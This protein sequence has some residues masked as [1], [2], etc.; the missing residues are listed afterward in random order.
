MFL[1]ARAILA[2]LF[3]L[4]LA[5]AVLAQEGSRATL[6]DR[7]K[8]VRVKTLL[9]AGKHTEAMPLLK[10]VLARHPRNTT[11][12]YLLAR[13]R[14][15]AG[16]RAAATKVTRRIL[17]LE[18]TNAR[19]LVLSAKLT[20]AG[21]TTTASPSPAMPPSPA[22]AAVAPATGPIRLE[23]TMVT[24]WDSRL[25]SPAA[26]DVQE[27][28][29][30]FRRVVKEE[31]SDRFALEVASSEIPSIGELFASVDYRSTPLFKDYSKHRYD[32]EQGAQALV[33]T[34]PDARRIRLA[35]LEKR[36]LEELAA[37]LPRESFESHD[38]FH[39]RLMEV[40]HQKVQWLQ[41]IE[42]SD[43]GGLLQVPAV[44]YQSELEWM[45]MMSR[46][47]RW[48]LVLTN[49]LVLADLT[50][51]PAPHALLR[52]AKIGGCAYISPSRRVLEGR[53]MMVSLIEDYCAVPGISVETEIA[54][55][56]KN[57]LVGAVLLAHEFGHAFFEIPDVYDHGKE[58]LMD[59]AAHSDTHEQCYQSLIASP[60]PCGKCRPWIDSRLARLEARVAR[61][62]GDASRAAALYHR[63]LQLLPEVLASGRAAV[64]ESI[65]DEA[66]PVF[67]ESGHEAG[68]ALIADQ[69][70][71]P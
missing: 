35:H 56:R 58:C 7:Q 39:D 36:S 65:A 26:E 43:G 48:D 33:F 63:S 67:Q 70:A 64:L 62:S 22:V 53:S 13:T 6:T 31:L 44:P 29:G 49:S 38:Q 60:G 10:D 23:M 61:D 55:S 15:A 4:V 52:H 24:S 18:P 41:G 47:D 5:G 27:I 69:A 9:L 19:A 57:K 20:Q 1:P 28:L 34:H 51:V 59:S 8:L 32:L 45:C 71:G 50:A 42:L 17:E 66:A 46:Q 54:R 14:L 3:C 16:D 37:T 30:E 12:L 2:V 11:V 40:Y 68:L 25:P 21:S